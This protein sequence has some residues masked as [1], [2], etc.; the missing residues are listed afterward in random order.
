MIPIGDPNG[1]AIY[2]NIFTLFTINKKTLDVSINIPAPFGS[3]MG[4]AF[5]WNSGMP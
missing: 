5:A 1:A 3:V 4:Y 2:G